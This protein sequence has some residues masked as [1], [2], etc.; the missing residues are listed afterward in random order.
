MSLPDVIRNAFAKLAGATAILRNVNV[1]EI[2]EALTATNQLRL[3]AQ[4]ADWGSDEDVG[5]IIDHAIIAARE[6]ADVTATQLDDQIV[7]KVGEL[8]LSA[9]RWLIEAMHYLAGKDCAN[10]DDAY[11]ALHEF[12]A[13][14]RPM[15][16]DLPEVQAGSIMVW[17][18]FAILLW[19]VIKPLIRK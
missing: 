19:S 11:V 5:A 4:H 17:I 14:N 1:S 2:G 16:E 12:A 8:T 13:T 15:R 9:K 10:D 6:W 3:V 18:E 7:E